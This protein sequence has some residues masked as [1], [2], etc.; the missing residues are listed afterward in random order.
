MQPRDDVRAEA[1]FDP[2]LKTYFFLYGVWVL[3][4]SVVG[5]I[6]LPF[7]LAL[8][9]LWARRY[10]ESLACLLTERSL[11]VKK[12]VLFRTEKTIPLDKIQDFSLKEGPLLRKLGLAKLDIETAG[13]GSSQG[14]AEAALVGVMD[15]YAFRDRVLTQRDAVQAHHRR[16]PGPALPEHGGAPASSEQVLSD[17]RDTLQRIE[18]HL[19]QTAPPTEK[20][21]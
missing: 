11:V 10:Y 15:V 7:W 3:T 2:K 17:I 14:N 13:G 12:G 5:L 6:V 19:R 20:E 4:I 16:T 1:R 18:R 9:Y 8:G 21:Q